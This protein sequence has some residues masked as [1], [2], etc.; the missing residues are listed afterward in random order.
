MGDDARKKQKQR[1]KRRQKRVAARRQEGSSPYRKFAGEGEVTACYIN[2][3]WRDKGM[4]SLLVLKRTPGGSLALGAFLVDIWCLGLKDAW[5][6]INITRGEFQE[7]LEHSGENLE[8]VRIDP[9]TAWRLVSGGVRFARQNGFRLPARYERWT[10][11]L[12]NNAECSSADLS[13]FGVEGGKL[14][15][16]GTLEDLRSRLIGCS[17]EDFLH[18]K[19]VQFIVGGP[20]LGEDLDVDLDG[21][22]I[23]DLDDDDG[24]DEEED[25]E[26]DEVDAETVIDDLQQQALDAVRKWCFAKGVRPHPQLGEAIGLMLESIGQVGEADVDPNDEAAVDE[27]ARAAQDNIETLLSFT[28]PVESA[29][30]EGALSQLAEFYQQFKSADEALA[31]LG[32]EM[33]GDEQD[34]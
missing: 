28:T 19:D 14:R 20:A 24:F 34:G 12:G 15:Y 22:S 6:R 8:M 21:E 18:R 25:F 5:G 29:A 27:T 1:L 23:E 31:A 11:L 2:N 32:I 26:D 30:L 9:A 17:T 16:V 33:P 7:A 10:A 4:A 3:E 13:D